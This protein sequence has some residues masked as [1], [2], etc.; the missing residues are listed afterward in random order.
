MPN[1]PVLPV[2]LK[3][4]LSGLDIIL[5]LFIL[6]GIVRGLRRGLTGELLALL[7]TVMAVY[8]ALV[9]SAPA[10]E[11]L[12]NFAETETLYLR[13]A[14]GVFLF[15]IIKWGMRILT[16][17][18]I[19]LADFLYLG[20]LN[21]WLGAI[22]GG[23]KHIFIISVALLLLAATPMEETLLTTDRTSSSVLYEPLVGFGKK[24]L[25]SLAEQLQTALE[26]HRD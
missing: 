15:F 20:L 6:A 25:P 14:A 18:I 17:T 24:L 19:R 9:L 13:I 4:S 10:A 11:V 16:K 22:L 23:L 26:Q 5:G 8:A 21:R 3:I 12:K 7:S 1:F 2:M